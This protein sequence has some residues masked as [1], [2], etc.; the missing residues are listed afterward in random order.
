MA[1][2]GMQS[3]SKSIEEGEGEKDDPRGTDTG[4]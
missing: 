3:E 1:P 2:G 4:D